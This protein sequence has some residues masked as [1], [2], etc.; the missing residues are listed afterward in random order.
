MTDSW[1]SA[2]EVAEKHAQAGGTFVRLANDGDKVVGAFCGVPHTREVV[3]VDGHYELYKADKHPDKTP[4]PRFMLNI[5]VPA[6][7]KMKVIEQGAQWFK[8]VLKVREKYGLDTWLFE[9]QRSGAAGD[10]KTKYTVLPETKIDAELRA[11]I[12][13]AELHKLDK[14]GLSDVEDDEPEP[15]ERAA[16]KAAPAKPAAPA[17]HAKAAPSHPKAAAAGVVEVSVARELADRLKA[18]PRDEAMTFL[19]RFDIEKVRDLK[20]AD[21]T[22][23]RAFIADLEKKHAPAEQEEIDPFA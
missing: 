22:K 4:S 15:H 14:L 8:A 10:T 6:E 2:I 20:A 13:A 5:Y 17:A 9:V 16:S 18:L 12:D 23:A 1:E 11:Q 19:Q 7:G 21:E 3:W